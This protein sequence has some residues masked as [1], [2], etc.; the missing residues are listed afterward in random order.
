[1]T[2]RQT[3]YALLQQLGGLLEVSSWADA[4]CCKMQ[5]A[6]PRSLCAIAS[7]C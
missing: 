6:L 5:C 4:I 7:I 2:H 1:M 3:V